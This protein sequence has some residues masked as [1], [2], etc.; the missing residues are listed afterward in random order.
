MAGQQLSIGSN[1]TTTPIL[2]LCCLHH[3]HAVCLY[4]A[5]IFYSANKAILSNT[6]KVEDWLPRDFPETKTLEWFRESFGGQTFVV[7]SWPG[8]VLGGNPDDPLATPDDPR[9]ERLAKTLAPSKSYRKHGDAMV[10]TRLDESDNRGANDSNGLAEHSVVPE[11]Y[12]RYFNGVVTARRLIQQMTSAPSSLP[13]DVAVS[14]LKGSMIGPDGHQTSVIVFLSL[15]AEVGFDKIIGH[16]K[17]IGPGKQ[18]PGA[19][20]NAFW[21]SGIDPNTVHMGGPPVDNVAIDEEGQTTL[22][23]LARLS[24]A[25]T[26]FLAYV[27]LRSVKLTLMVLLTGLLSGA[28]S[29]AAVWWSGQNVDAILI[30]MPS[31]VY[32]L[33]ISGAIHI[34]NYYRESLETDGWQAAPYVAIRHAWRPSLLCTT[35]TALGLIS[36]VASDL[37]P[38]RKFGLYSAA[39]VVLTLLF[40][41]ALLPAALRLWPLSRTV[42]FRNAHSRLDDHDSPTKSSDHSPHTDVGTPDSISRTFGSWIIRHQRSVTIG[43]FLFVLTIGYGITRLG[44]SIDLLRLFDRDAQIQQDYRWLETNLGRLV[45]MELVLRVDRDVLSSTD[46][47]TP[48]E[49]TPLLLVD[50]MSLLAQVQSAIVQRFGVAGENIIGPPMSAISFVPE[51]PR[52]GVG[53]SSL[54]KRKTVDSQLRQSYDKFLQTSYLR[55]DQATDDELWRISIRV[56]AFQDVD[57][58]Q[59]TSEIQSVVEPVVAAFNQKHWGADRAHI[60]AL[61]TGVVPIVYKAQRALL[62]SLIESTFWSFITITPVLMLVC[63]GVLPGLVA[64]LPNVLPVLVVFGAMGWMGMDVDIGSMMSASIALGVAVDDTIH[65]LTWYR[66]ELQVCQDRHQAILAAYRRCAAPTVQ[67]ALV[68][69]LGLSVFALSTFT[70]TRQFGYLMLAILLAGMVAEL[71]LLPALLAGPLGRVFYADSSSDRDTTADGDELSARPPTRRHLR[72]GKI[73]AARER[74]VSAKRQVEEN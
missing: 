45:P 32:V 59:L 10:P 8:C 36:L 1:T 68:N 62:T 35:T 16:G 60:G 29:L 4:C 70:P 69:G 46:D 51:L 64:M 3:R 40:L 67:A 2:R 24:I 13:Y 15:S 17:S 23:Q 56:A 18:P 5:T 54:I 52:A 27:S 37:I 38:I 66:G 25:V 63:R 9:I 53:T 22:V 7:I 49:A 73:S 28:A 6:N 21:A 11:S 12:G 48:P 26:V 61:Y 58:G 31:L 44:T 39:G 33:A 71:V 41:F 34:V 50:R 57:Y 43:C 47:E 19:I 55:R 42:A 74:A 65:Y 14:R 72:F 20:W 30:S